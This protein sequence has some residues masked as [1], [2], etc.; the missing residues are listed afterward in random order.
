MFGSLAQLVEHIVHIDGVTGSSPVRTTTNTKYSRIF[1][2]RAV[3]GVFL[4]PNENRREEHGRAAGRPRRGGV[5][6]FGRESA[7]ESRGF[8]GAFLARGRRN[9]VRLD[10]AR[11]APC[12]ALS[13]RG[14]ASGKGGHS[15]GGDR[16]SCPAVGGARGVRSARGLG[17][18]A[19]PARKGGGPRRAPGPAGAA[20]RPALLELQPLPGSA[21]SIPSRRGRTSRRCSAGTG[22]WAATARSPTSC[23]SST[24]CRQSGWSR[25]KR[26]GRRWTG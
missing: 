23:A 24:A 9:P 1:A 13:C 21:G 20:A 2:R 6:C 16:G 15:I 17:G 11:G 10:R 3:L 7:P 12:A 25:D 4:F 22:R 5:R 18:G 14:R 26:G 19:A 8:Q